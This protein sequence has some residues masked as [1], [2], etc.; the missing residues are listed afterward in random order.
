MSRVVDSTDIAIVG[1]GVIAWACAWEIAR[2]G[3]RVVVLGEGASSASS[4]AA[5][6]IAP[7]SEAVLDGIDGKTAELWRRAAA[8]WEAS[9][10]ELGIDLRRSGGLH[11]GHPD[12]LASRSSLAQA[13]GFAAEETADGLLLLGDYVLD[14]AIVLRA[15][16]HKAEAAGTVF[17][18]GRV[19][20]G[21]DGPRFDGRP[22]KIPRVLIAAGWGA[23]TLAGWAP[24]L[25]VLEPIK[26]Q[27]L[28]VEGFAA[29]PT[30]RAQG[31]YLAPQA[32]GWAVGATMEVGR[33]DLTPDAERSAELMSAA[34]AARP[35]LAGARHTTAVGVRAAT[36][37]GAPLVGPSRTPGVLLAAGM[38]RNGWLLAPLVAQA[39]A[40]YEDGAPDAV[41][42]GQ[43]HAWDPARVFKTPAEGTA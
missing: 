34:V 42:G 40:A 32:W 39:V 31:A 6:M 25:A 8:A 7:A 24:E 11:V 2:R 15:L 1:D 21:P 4:A 30:I 37:D 35:E 38:R 20:F 23:A 13:L 27:L 3:R 12:E 18:A 41:L 28:K 26:G 5:G 36:P 19:V 14:P 43:A 16:R 22:F 9:A 17:R 29:G 33:S 10:L